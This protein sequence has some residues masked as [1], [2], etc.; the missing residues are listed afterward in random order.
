MCGDH[1][2]YIYEDGGLYNGY[3]CTQRLCVGSWQY[4][5]DIHTTV[6]LDQAPFVMAT[7]RVW[8][9]WTYHYTV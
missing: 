6:C 4:Q 2:N 7:S 9:E 5:N 3:D 1:E 8:T